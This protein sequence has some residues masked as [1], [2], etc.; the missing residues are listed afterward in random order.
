MFILNN[1]LCSSQ[2]EIDLKSEFLLSKGTLDF[3]EGDTALNITI[4]AL[5]DNL[6]EYDE[7]FTLLL[8]NATGICIVLRYAQFF[9][10]LNIAW[11]NKIQIKRKNS[12]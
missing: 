11:Q 10:S 2:D 6:P 4:E 3:E 1:F 9:L 7:E 5:I 12:H 8:A